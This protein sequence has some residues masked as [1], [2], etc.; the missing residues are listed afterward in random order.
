MVGYHGCNSF[1]NISSKC[2]NDI[3]KKITANIL[4]IGKN[5]NTGSWTLI[6]QQN[7]GVCTQ[8]LDKSW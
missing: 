8:T 3:N 7:T 1:I 5:K 2:W 6:W 4:W